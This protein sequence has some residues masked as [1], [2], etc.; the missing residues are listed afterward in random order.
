[1]SPVR[2]ASH[3]SYSR[4]VLEGRGTRQRETLLAFLA[5]NPRPEAWTRNELAEATGIRLSSVCSVVNGLLGEPDP[6]VLELDLR[7]D[8]HTTFPARPVALVAPP[9]ATVQ[10]GFEG[11]LP[12]EASR[13]MPS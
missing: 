2:Y 5:E 10:R 7:A 1:M 13:R 11:F 4:R 6:L 8:G 3:R 9:P 12:S